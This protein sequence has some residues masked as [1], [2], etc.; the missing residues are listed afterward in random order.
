MAATVV[1]LSGAM[2]L[3]PELLVLGSGVVW[4]VVATPLLL[5]FHGW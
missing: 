2:F 1:V 5:R 4:F 3:V